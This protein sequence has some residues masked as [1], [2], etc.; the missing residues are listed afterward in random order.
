[1]VGEGE[2]E[3]A[4]EGEG[5][6]EGEGGGGGGMERERKNGSGE[7]CHAHKT[8]FCEFAYSDPMSMC[9]KGLGER[10]R[11]RQRSSRSYSLAYT[12]K[13]TSSQQYNSTH[14]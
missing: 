5:E 12:H 8:T 13:Y 3:R 2:G 11:G 6:R 1:M 9:R 14:S 4:G 7:K 10:L